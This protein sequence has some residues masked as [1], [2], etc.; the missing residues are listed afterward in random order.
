MEQELKF[1]TLMIEPPLSDYCLYPYWTQMAPV[2]GTT[3][4]DKVRSYCIL[5]L[6]KNLQI[7]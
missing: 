1:Q 4:V 6:L 5:S 3:R 2:L 7:E